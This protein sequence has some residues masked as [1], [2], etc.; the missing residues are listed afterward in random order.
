MGFILVKITS[1]DAR[2]IYSCYNSNGKKVNDN[3]KEITIYNFDH[4]VV[5]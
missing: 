2:I 4:I 1:D 3:E 5:N